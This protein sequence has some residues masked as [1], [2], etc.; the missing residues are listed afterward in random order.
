MEDETLIIYQ[1]FKRDEKLMELMGGV[2][3]K[4]R[5]IYNNPA[6]PYSEEF[7]RATIIET[8]AGASD[9]ADDTA[10]LVRYHVRVDFWHIKNDLTGI[11]CR[12]KEII[13][14]LF[15]A[16]YTSYGSDMYESDTGIYHKQLEIDVKL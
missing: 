14:N 15:P 11:M 13:D 9:C 16:V 1:A 6:A 3:D 4:Y 12:A 8:Y 7:P 10:A 2:T 5:R